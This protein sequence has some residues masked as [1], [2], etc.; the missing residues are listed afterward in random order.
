MQCFGFGIE[1]KDRADAIDRLALNI[2]NQLIEDL[3][4]L[5]SERDG[6]KGFILYRQEAFVAGLYHH[7]QSYRFELG[8]VNPGALK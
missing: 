2:V 6:L 7:S 4:D 8:L 3:G 5:L 1:K